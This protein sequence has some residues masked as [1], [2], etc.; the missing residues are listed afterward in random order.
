[1][2]VAC[3]PTHRCRTPPPLCAMDS[4]PSSQ[5][6]DA[7]PEQ[8]PVRPVNARAAG[9]IRRW[10]TIVLAIA[11]AISPAICLAVLVRRHAVNV[12]LN[13]DFE[14]AELM[15]KAKMGGLT[16]HDFIYAHLEHRPVVSRIIIALNAAF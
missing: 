5:G 9:S 2:H 4:E 1:W 11:L 7:S 10:L 15:V 16:F 13:D 14:Y 6:S 8:P 12:M 3:R